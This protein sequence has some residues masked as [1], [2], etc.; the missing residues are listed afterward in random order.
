MNEKKE[1]FIY[2]IDWFINSIIDEWND[3]NFICLFIHTNLK[4]DFQLMNISVWDYKQVAS[5]KVNNYRPN[6]LFRCECLPCMISCL[7]NQYFIIGHLI[8]SSSSSSSEKYDF[9]SAYK[10]FK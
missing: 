3:N 9:I 7:H 2:L 8:A 6:T 5:I 1:Q 10:R 4:E